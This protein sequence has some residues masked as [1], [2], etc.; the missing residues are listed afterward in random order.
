[1]IAQNESIE[2]A[3]ARI[4]AINWMQYDSYS[5]SRECSHILLF[6]EYIRRAALWFKALNIEL[7]GSG[8]PVFDIAAQ[9]DQSIEDETEDENFIK[10]LTTGTYYTKVLCLYYVH[11]SMIKDRPEVTRFNLP[12]PYEPIIIMFE[13]G[14]SFP[15]KEFNIYDFWGGGIPINEPENYYD[16]LPYTEL[17]SATLD[18]ID[19]EYQKSKSKHKVGS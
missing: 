5:N 16:D 3:I 15:R 9:I 11:W 12:E 4:K 19:L 7:K 13:R 18:Q 6:K 10:C 8:W 14:C 1:M 2:T 17:D